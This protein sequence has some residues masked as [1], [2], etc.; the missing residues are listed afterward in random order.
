MVSLPRTT[1]DGR[2]AKRLV[3]AA[4]IGLA[5]VVG[6]VP[7]AASAYPH[8]KKAP[9]LVKK[10]SGRSADYRPAGAG[11]GRRIR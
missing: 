9:G 11:T 7:A 10:G 5:L 8:H 4:A 1:L 6:G 3:L 2:S